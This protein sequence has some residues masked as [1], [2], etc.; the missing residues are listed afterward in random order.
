MHYRVQYCYFKNVALF[1]KVKGSWFLVVFGNILLLV[2]IRH[3]TINLLK[4]NLFRNFTRKRVPI[5]WR[6]RNSPLT[7]FEY[8]NSD[9]WRS[10]PLGDQT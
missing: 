1:I 6:N 2:S 4:T 9:F 10:N 8:Y 5:F 7:K 3:N